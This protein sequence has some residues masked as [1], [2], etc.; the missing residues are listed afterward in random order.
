MARLMM[1]HN[2]GLLVVVQERVE[3]IVHG[4]RPPIE[5]ALVGLNGHSHVL[6]DVVGGVIGW[7]N[8]GET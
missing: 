8:G 6:I 5:S 4:G 1:A 2:I 3:S 7:G